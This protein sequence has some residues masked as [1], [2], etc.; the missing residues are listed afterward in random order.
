MIKGNKG[1]TTMAVDREAH[2]GGGSGMFKTVGLCHFRPW[3]ETIERK[4]KVLKS[5]III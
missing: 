1:G 4:A 3:G 2:A 5:Y